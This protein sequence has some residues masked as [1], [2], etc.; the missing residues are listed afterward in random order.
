[1][2]AWLCKIL[3]ESIFQAAK[4]YRR[5][6]QAALNFCQVAPAQAS[7]SPNALNT[8]SNKHN[9]WQH[10]K[11]QTAAGWEWPIY[12]SM[13]WQSER[14]AAPHCQPLSGSGESGVTFFYFSTS[15]IHT[16][17]NIISIVCVINLLNKKG[18]LFLEWFHRHQNPHC[19]H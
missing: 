14:C 8:V 11:Q 4:N 16:L 9:I 13:H 3:L 1:M 6:M 5:P 18:N 10:G 7:P 12:V 15:S 2:M 19:I 17:Q